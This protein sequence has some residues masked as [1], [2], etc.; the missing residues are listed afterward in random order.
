M[1]VEKMLKDLL[2]PIVRPIKTKYEELWSNATLDKSAGEVKAFDIL[3]AP[4]IIV[5]VPDSLCNLELCLPHI[6]K[7]QNLLIVGN[8]L[9]A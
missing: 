3:E 4:Y 9:P 6:P 7:Q 8:C 1:K 5:A 2:R